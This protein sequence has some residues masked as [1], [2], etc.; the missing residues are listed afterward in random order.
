[1]STVPEENQKPEVEKQKAKELQEN[2]IRIK[3][4]LELENVSMLIGAGGSFHLGAPIIRTIPDELKKEEF[5]QEIIARYFPESVAPSVEDVIN[6]LQADRFIKQ[7]KGEAHAETQIDSSIQLIQQWLFEHCNTEE[8]DLAKSYTNDQKLKRN[9]Y[10]YH[11]N[12][13]KKLLQ[14]PN[15]LK[16]V[17][18][19][20]TNYDMAF[21]YAL[22]NLGVHYINGFTGVHNRCFRPEV[23]DY[24]LYYPGKSVTGKVH[25]AEKV[26]KYYKLHGSLSWIATE[27]D[28]GNTY[29]IKEI[30]VDKKF[31][32]ADNKELIIYPCVSKKSFV[33]DLPYS[34]LFRQ[35]AQAI[36][37]PQSVLFC[38]GHSFYDEH[39]NDIIKQAL[40]VPSFTLIIV[41]YDP[42]NSSESNSTKHP[43][44]E[45]KQLED[46]RILI[47]D[48]KDEKQS[49]FTGFV[50]NVLP[51]LYEEDEN[52]TIAETKRKLYSSHNS[53]DDNI[54]A[55]NNR[56]KEE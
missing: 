21:D 55:N 15:N 47:L 37:Q 46:K 27:P 1:M 48:Q 49:T 40:S 36:H 4:Y 31:T 25:R 6:C 51:D 35:F 9:R 20:T 5:T 50:E 2:K 26:L 39:I 52:N 38:L 29:G 44:D 32:I 14:R 10:A 53:D 18:L 8:I 24:D 16:R 30:P 43:I 3:K 33:L 13:I 28:Y 7:K 22:D 41:N 17:N 11:E 42:A 12:L 54:I 56:I 19:F 23:Y 45:F 34:E